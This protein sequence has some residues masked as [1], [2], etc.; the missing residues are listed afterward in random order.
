M[1]FDWNAIYERHCELLEETI[2][3]GFL[4]EM[5]DVVVFFTFVVR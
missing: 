4:R 3:S 5:Y 1:S 2:A